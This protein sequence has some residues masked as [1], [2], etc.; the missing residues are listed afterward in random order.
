MKCDLSPINIIDEA[1]AN[2]DKNND[3]NHRAT[4]KRLVEGKNWFIKSNEYFLLSRLISPNQSLFII[5]DKKNGIF[6]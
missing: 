5:G 3:N 2:N 1:T 4:S 6:F